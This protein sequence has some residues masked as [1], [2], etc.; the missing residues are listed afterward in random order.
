MDR[1]AIEPQFVLLI[2]VAGLGC[3]PNS[4]ATHVAHEG[5]AVPTVLTRRDTCA[6]V[7]RTAIDPGVRPRD[8]AGEYLLTLVGQTP[9]QIVWHR[10]LWLWPTSMKDVSPRTRATPQPNDTVIHPLYGVSIIDSGPV[11]PERSQQLRRAV[12]PIYPAVL[13]EAQQIGSTVSTEL[14]RTI[15]LLGPGRR[16]GVHLED[17]GGTGMY[18][19]QLDWRG[20][21]G[22]FEPWGG[23]VDEQ[24]YY[25]AER[26]AH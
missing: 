25:C 19:K 6:P 9:V 13:V 15:L 12:D 16:D 22:D 24:G 7:T 11:S 1:R 23:Q 14:G 17:G 4:S 21:R 18:L 20:F 3:E 10:R 5:V 2:L 8:L 26:I